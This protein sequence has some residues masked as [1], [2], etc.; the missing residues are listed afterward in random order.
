M[1]VTKTDQQ[2]LPYI[3][4]NVVFFKGPEA[5]RSPSGAG[6]TDDDVETQAVRIFEQMQHDELDETSK[7]VKDQL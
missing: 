2:I 1:S 4:D 3:F 7:S 6:D 5:V